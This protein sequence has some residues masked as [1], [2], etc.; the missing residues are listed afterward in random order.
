MPVG[1]WATVPGSWADIWVHGQV[2]DRVLLSE[3]FQA[4]F[5]IH[6]LSE[7]GSRVR[8]FGDV[9]D[10]G[11]QRSYS[12]SNLVSSIWSGPQFLSPSE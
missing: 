6:T 9:Y 10:S 7:E 2:W 5:S 4:Q 8:S 1:K 12:D 11:G 3:K